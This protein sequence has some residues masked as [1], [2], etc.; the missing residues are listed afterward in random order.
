MLAPLGLG[1]LGCLK[2]AYRLACTAVRLSG[3]KGR[4][5]ASAAAVARC[6]MTWAWSLGTSRPSVPSA[7]DLV[8]WQDLEHAGGHRV[9]EVMERHGLLDHGAIHA[10][11][12]AG[13][14]DEVLC[15]HCS[16]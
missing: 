15:G 6:G 16:P 4:S 14:C 10:D 13:G 5:K 12:P 3:A 11:Q 2:V 8:R 7:R 9:A 1:G